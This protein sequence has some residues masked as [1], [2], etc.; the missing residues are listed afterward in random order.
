MKTINHG[1][2]GAHGER[3]KEVAFLIREI[4]VHPWLGGRSVFR[5]NSCRSWFFFYP[6]LSV[7]SVSEWNKKGGGREN[8]TENGKNPVNP[9]HPAA[10]AEGEIRK[11]LEYQAISA[12]G[13][14]ASACRIGQNPAANPA[15]TWSHGGA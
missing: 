2:H 7:R 12:L 4:C 13:L 3:R 10:N 9:V 14:R 1:G 15:A 6:G 8:K 5:D 11:R